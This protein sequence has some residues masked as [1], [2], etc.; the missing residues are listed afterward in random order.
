MGFIASNKNFIHHEL[1]RPMRN[2]NSVERVVVY[3]SIQAE[4]RKRLKKSYIE[5][6]A[7]KEQFYLE[8]F[9]VLGEYEGEYLIMNLLVESQWF[10]LLEKVFFSNNNNL[11][12]LKFPESFSRFLQI[13]D[14]S[15]FESENSDEVD[16]KINYL[17]Y[18]LIFFE[19]CLESNK[20]LV[21]EFFS[22]NSGLNQLIRSYVNFLVD[23]KRENDEKFWIFLLFNKIWKEYYLDKSLHRVRGAIFYRELNNKIESEKCVIKHIKYLDFIH[24]KLADN[25]AL[26]DFTPIHLNILDFENSSQ[27]KKFYLEYHD[28]ISKG[29]FLMNLSDESS[30]KEILDY[31]EKQKIFDKRSI[32]IFQKKISKFQ[33]PNSNELR[34]FKEMYLEYGY[35]NK[36]TKKIARS[37]Y[38]YELL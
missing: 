15:K 22:F 8:V 30:F 34:Y 29:R 10:R 6:I 35:M 23:E 2:L 37:L 9:D 32:E 36:D 19:N 33:Y 28:S 16:E 14:M 21:K 31:V 11:N 18:I 3:K 7:N 12:G 1:T 5:C 24:N 25:F 38:L 26:I 13:I 4:T 17:K 20:S 27:M